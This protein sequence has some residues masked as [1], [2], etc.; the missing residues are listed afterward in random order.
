MDWK[1]KAHIL[2]DSTESEPTKPS[3]PGF[4]GFEGATSGPLSKIQ[5]EE[6]A[7][8]YSPRAN[9]IPEH[10]ESLEAVLKGAAVDLWSDGERFWLVADEEDA[11]RLCE[12]RGSVYTAAEARHL[13]TVADAS[14]VREIHK[15]KRT[16]NAII[17]EVVQD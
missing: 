14:I 1:P 12:R 4:V 7:T 9:K 5:S 10:L 16:T 3:E 8:L 2:A 6:G 11:T 13:V 15:W 17:R